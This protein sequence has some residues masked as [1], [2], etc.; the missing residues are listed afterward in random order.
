[1]TVRTWIHRGWKD[2]FDRI[3]ASE[4]DSRTDAAA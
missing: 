2:R 3:V 1:M 4:V